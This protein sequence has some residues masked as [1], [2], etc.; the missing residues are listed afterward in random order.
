[1]FAV[2]ATQ[3]LF[4]FF[5]CVLYA[6]YSKAIFEPREASICKRIH[7]TDIYWEPVLSLFLVYVSLI[8]WADGFGMRFGLHHVDFNDPARTRTPKAS[9]AWY[10]KFVADHPHFG[11]PPN[12]KPTPDPL[13]V[14]SGY[15]AWMSPVIRGTLDILFRSLNNTD[16][17]V[18]FGTRYGLAV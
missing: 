17:A 5:V 6:F 11:T 15:T 16:G 3:N 9:A 12:R 7:L 13:E 18:I 14:Y 8:R 4:E 10:G 2:S 1:M